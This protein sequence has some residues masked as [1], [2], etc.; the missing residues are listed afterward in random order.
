MSRS[1][2]K[3]LV[4]VTRSSVGN[5]LSFGVGKRPQIWRQA[6]ESLGFEG[7]SLKLQQTLV[8]AA[9]IAVASACE[10]ETMEANPERYV[11]IGVELTMEAAGARVVRVIDEGPAAAS[12]LAKNDVVLEI[13]GVPA[14]GMSLAEVVKS[15]RGEPGSSVKLLART[16]EGNKELHVARKAISNR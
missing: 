1:C 16:G 13:E 11:G 7:M 8:L 14:R 6:F 12:G 5:E 10:R 9:L 3:G 2:F 15:L 4:P